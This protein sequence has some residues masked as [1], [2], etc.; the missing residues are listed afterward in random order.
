VESWADFLAPYFAQGSACNLT[1]TYSD[2]YGYKNGLMLARNVKADFQRFRQYLGRDKVAACMG[3]ERGPQ[4]VSS[5]RPILHFH[6]MLAGEWSADEL[7]DV[8]RLWELHRGWSRA[9]AVTDRGGCVEYAAK[10]LLKG[11]AED[12][13]AFWTPRQLFVSRQQRRLNAES[14]STG[15]SD[16]ERRSAGACRVGAIEGR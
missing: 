5:G 8:E 4:A 9:K 10:H 13:F 12:N 11:G 14:V 1:G 7:R 16:A 15:F 6:A 2:A 3:I